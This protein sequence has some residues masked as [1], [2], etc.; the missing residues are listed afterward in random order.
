MM[1]QAIPI[2][3][4]LAVAGPARADAEFF[5]DQDA[6]SQAIGGDF[7]T[8]TFADIGQVVFLDEQYAH[9]GIHFPETNDHRLPE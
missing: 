2:I 3:A 5:A 7:T 4:A 1:R 8:I 9:L 6:W